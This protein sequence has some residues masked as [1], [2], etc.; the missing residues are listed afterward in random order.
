M[1]DIT[2]SA[3]WRN[4]RAAKYTVSNSRESV[5]TIFERRSIFTAVDISG[6]LLGAFSTL[7]EA[8]AALPGVEASS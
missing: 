1:N 3:T 6:R 8:A 4:W 5:G 7:N 2:I